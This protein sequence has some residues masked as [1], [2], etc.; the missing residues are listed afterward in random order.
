M[1]NQ[2]K[3]EIIR[4]LLNGRSPDDV[5]VTL[6][7]EKRVIREVVNDNPDLVIDLSEKYKKAGIPVKTI[8]KWE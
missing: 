3:I 4:Q 6:K 5:S 8:S 1:T 2:K 7:V